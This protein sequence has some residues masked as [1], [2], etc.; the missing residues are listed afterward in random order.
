MIIITVAI[1][2]ASQ[3]LA[4]Y[5]HIALEISANIDGDYTLGTYIAKTLNRD[6]SDRIFTEGRRIYESI[7]E[8]IRLDRESDEYLSYFD[9]LKTDDYFALKQLMTEL[10]ADGEIKWIDFRIMDE[11][12]GRV[13]FLL[14]T[15]MR[16]DKLYSPGYWQYKSEVENTFKSNEFDDEESNNYGHIVI[17]VFRGSDDEADRQFCTYAPYYS[18]D[19]KLVGYIGVGEVFNSYEE[20]LSYF[21]FIYILVMLVLIFVIL[22]I[23]TLLIH[24]LLVKPLRR[25]T[26]AA[27]EY[28]RTE[29]KS[30]NKH[31]FDRLQIKTHDEVSV[32]AGSMSDLENEISTYI[33]DLTEVTAEKERVSA[34]LDVGARIQSAMLPE[35]LNGYDGIKDF[36]ISS[37]IKPAKEVG[38]DFYDYFVID[39]DHI[40]LVIA[41]VSGKGVPAALFMVIVKT[42]IKNTGLEET[43]P[44]RVIEKVN[45]QLCENNPET[46]FATVWYGIYQISDHSIRYVNAGHEDPVVYRAST[47]RYEMIIDEHDIMLGF[48]PDIAFTERQIKLLPGDKLLQYTDGIPEGTR[49]DE[50]M[51]GTGRMLDHLNAST[52]KSGMEILTSLKD[53]VIGFSDGAPQFDDMTMILLEVVS[54]K[55][56]E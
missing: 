32:L 25:L 21:R 10:A 34:E 35:Q 6:V 1:F 33:E 50:A 29:D 23:A 8:E 11:E 24:Y 45:R 7:P 5:M 54:D 30:V 20:D 3:F 51:Y 41:D 4:S 19:G 48:D 36:E 18:A 44:L 17:A 47:G 16:D 27:R 53:D 52:D 39:D 37:F 2:Y 40:G 31:I 9:E 49:E 14:D 38:G 42:L 28:G 13:I 26:A 56:E 43:S 12:T 15:E 55:S 22:S 46:M